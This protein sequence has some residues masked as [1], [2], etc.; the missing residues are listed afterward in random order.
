MYRPAGIGQVRLIELPL[1]ALPSRNQ[2]GPCCDAV[3]Q[4]DVSG[5]TSGNEVRHLQAR[6]THWA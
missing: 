5:A 1:K 6:A 3:K 4:D 2:T